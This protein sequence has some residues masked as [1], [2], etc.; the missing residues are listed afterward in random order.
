MA[1]KFDSMRKMH[2]FDG[3]IKPEKRTLFYAACLI[4]AIALFHHHEITNPH[5]VFTVAMVALGL[6]LGIYAATRSIMLTG[7]LA[8]CMVTAIVGIAAAS[9]QIMLH[10][11]QSLDRGITITSSGTVTALDGAIDRRIRLWIALD[12]PY[13]ELSTGRHPLIRIST[14]R[15]SSLPTIGDHIAFTA[16]LYPSPTP[17]LPRSP[18]YALQAQIR[19]VTASG[20]VIG[21]LQHND[22][23][24][25]NLADRLGRFR[26]QFAMQLSRDMNKPAG[27][28]AAALMVGDRRFITEATYE[29]F[30]KSGLAH[31]LAI[32]GL[33]MGLLCFGVIAAVRALAS[34]APRFSMR[35]PVHKYAAVAGVITGL[36][37][38]FVSGASI[39][40][41]RAF[42]MALFVISAILLDRLALTLRNVALT[43]MFVLILNPAALYT[44]SFQLSFAATIA[45]VAW[46]EFHATRPRLISAS[47]NPLLAYIGGVIIASLIASTATAPFTAQHFGAVTPWGVVANIM[48]IPLTG[49]WIMPSGIL[50]VIGYMTGLEAYVNGIMQAG[51]D[52][53]VSLAGYISSL[54][55]AGWRIYPPGYM[56]LAVLSAG[57]LLCIGCHYRAYP[58]GLLLLVLAGVLWWRTEIPQGVLFAKGQTRFL[59]MAGQD[60]I[61][62]SHSS[63]NHRRLSSFFTD[64]A[65]RQLARPVHPAAICKPF[66]IDYMADGRKVTVVDRR[67]NLT[68]ACQSQTDII[69]SLVP[70]KYPC[71]NNVKIYDM[72]LH[73]GYNS[74]IY[75]DNNE[76]V[77]I[78][79]NSVSN[80]RVCPV[81]QPH[82]C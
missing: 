9:L 54:P 36:G 63:Q 65:E 41:V 50:V 60:G 46:Y 16:R 28:I 82:P 5:I 74:L 12:R 29:T 44:A 73:Y 55:W 15:V 10:P 7:F 25:D 51:I 58:F 39:S 52:M 37:Y 40:A 26:N 57:C 33:H 70:V 3:L 42:I 35:V 13:R 27:G 23:Q 34:L 80:Q 62:H 2:L 31:L 75:I 19:N 47:R 77:Y 67:F 1:L 17:I 48:G 49:L 69:L 68:T 20:F 66:C 81:P 38:V 61:A 64:I 11:P 32:S 8:R 6:W 76:S 24:R 22:D 43:A 18:D 72:T 21:D 45:L 79:N 53:L 59:I 78:S 71:R 4:T 14:D 30:R 56:A